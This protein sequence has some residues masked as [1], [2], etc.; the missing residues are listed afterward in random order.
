MLLIR[1]IGG[2]SDVSAHT[3]SVKHED[4][5]AMGRPM[6]P[7]TAYDQTGVAV[8]AT[9]VYAGHRANA[10]RSAGPQP[11]LAVVTALGRCEWNVVTFRFVAVPAVLL[12]PEA[13]REQ[14]DA[15]QGDEAEDEEEGIRHDVASCT[16]RTMVRGCDIWP[17]GYHD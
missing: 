16:S 15:R 10:T 8:G 14:D 17:N 12:P 7:T 2:S 5:V 4:N 3:L 9:A 11:S 1:A 13:D 6:T